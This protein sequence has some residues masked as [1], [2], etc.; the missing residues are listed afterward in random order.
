MVSGTT[1]QDRHNIQVTAIV[2][3]ARLRS[4]TFLLVDAYSVHA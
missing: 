4:E 2:P 1:F 3:G